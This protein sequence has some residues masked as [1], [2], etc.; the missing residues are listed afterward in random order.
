MWSAFQGLACDCPP[1]SPLNASTYD[2]YSVIFSGKVDSVS[3]CSTK[4]FSKAFFTISDL[5]KG[6][7]LQHVAVE[8]DCS[9]SCM[10]SF[11]KG[12][13]WLIYAIYE[14]FDE[15]SV[16]L[17][18]HSRKQAAA[19]ESDVYAA[20]TGRSFDQEYQQLDHDLGKQAF[21]KENPLNDQQ[22]E[23]KPHNDQPSDV[24]KIVLLGISLIVMSGIIYYSRKRK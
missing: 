19:G 2:R 9:S 6:N 21:L 5:F 12:D 11:S 3:N 17:C 20:T 10:M 1:L 22:R 15:L 24:G 23:L 16:N 7:S 18:G 13:Q 14:R 4:G 8:F